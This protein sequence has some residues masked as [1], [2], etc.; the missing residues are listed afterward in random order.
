M[1]HAV[2]QP[3]HP[4]RGLGG[5]RIAG[6]FCDQLYVLACRKAWHQIVELEDE[7]HM[8]TPVSGESGFICL[9][10]V[11]VLEPRL[12]RCCLVKST[13]NVEECRLA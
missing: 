3:D 7:T 10:E 5:H 13:D 8:V 2:F 12:T 4:E 6:D 9:N 11:L 1:V